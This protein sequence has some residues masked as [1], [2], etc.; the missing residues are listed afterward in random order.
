ME[1]DETW[2]TARMR[3]EVVSFNNIYYY[4]CTEALSDLASR[5]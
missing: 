2:W 5:I 4:P 3:R 1:D